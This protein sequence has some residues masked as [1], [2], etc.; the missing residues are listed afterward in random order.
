MQDFLSVWENLKDSSTGMKM[1][2]TI[3]FS[4]FEF[5][6]NF[7]KIANDVFHVLCLIISYGFIYI[8]SYQI[9]TFEYIYLLSKDKK[10]Q[11]KQ[12]F[13]KNNQNICLPVCIFQSN[14]LIHF[15]DILV[16][17]F[18]N[19]KIFIEIKK[20]AEILLKRSI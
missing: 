5:E 7:A 9:E 17:R 6:N 13:L 15:V 18:E 12:F 14:W 2:K 16:T 4:Y 3:T 10:C 11:L 1:F 19:M 20:N 8:K